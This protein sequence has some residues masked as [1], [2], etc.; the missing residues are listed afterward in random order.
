MSKQK[1]QRNDPCPC[2]SGKKYKQCCALADARVAAPVDPLASLLQQALV[3]HQRGMLAQA[4]DLYDQILALRPQH[5]DAL[6]LRGL[7]DFQNGETV[8]AV[9]RMR[10][11]IAQNANEPRYFYN[12]GT[13]LMKLGEQDEAAT[14][15]RRVIE[16]DPDN[17]DAHG[18]L[19]AALGGLGET[20]AAIE[21]YRKAIALRPT[22]I[23]AL[24]S[25]GILLTLAGQFAEAVRVTAQ[26]LELAPDN[27]L[28][29]NSMGSALLR[30][31]RA[32]DAAV[33]FERATVLSPNDPT[34][35]FNLADTMQARS[36]LNETIAL[37]RRGLALGPDNALAHSN[38]LLALQYSPSLTPAQLFA[39]HTRFA[40]QFEPAGNVTHANTPDPARRIRI[41]Y[42]SADLRD[43]A[44]ARFIEP[45]LRH[46]DAG[47]VEV[48]CYYN[49]YLND[50]TNARMRAAVQHWV[51]CLHLDAD[52]LAARIRA[53][54]IDILIDLSGH[55]AGNRLLTFARKP[56]PLQVTF[57]GYPGTTGLAAMD[58]RISDALLDPVGVTDQFYTEKILRLES[59]VIYQPAA[60]CPEVNPL[61]CL[62]GAPFTFACLN[63][64][65]KITPYAI[66][67][68]SQILKRLPASRLML[69]NLQEPEARARLLANFAAEGIGL[70]RLVLLP[71]MALLD[72]LATYHRIDLTLD[73]FPYTGGTT[74]NDS[75]WMGVPILTLAGQTSV[76]RGTAAALQVAGLPQFVTTSPEQ[77][78]DTAVAL[79]TD[80]AGLDAVR[81]TI[82]ARLSANTLKDP[83]ALTRNLEA[84]LRGIWRDWCQ[85]QGAATA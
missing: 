72:Y 60:G 75:L 24:C 84:L 15:F 25:L 37:Y 10:A 71:K 74:T 44:V 30:D 39:E 2:G 54:G 81:Q 70:E 51:P 9:A 77:Y 68:W 65:I 56:A 18:N 76:S 64:L 79:A 19:A 3:E 78:I 58:Y 59:A 32:D 17:A 42:V 7:I 13:A 26:A 52:Q 27:V 4:S 83:V 62:H 69:G 40:Q 22:D 29:N 33:F 53:D 49:H 50:A 20:D 67:V 34:G 80:P 85:A 11:A 41:G 73:T 21:S 45:I 5:A 61:P 43:H 47:Q 82:R 23:G 1:V 28:A 8:A 55:T 36:R 46:H 38:L 63:N 48:F 16:D 6:H 12:L 35:W 66:A 57:N 14:Q 31:G